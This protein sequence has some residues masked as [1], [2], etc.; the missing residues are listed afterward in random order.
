MEMYEL[1][2]RYFVISVIGSVLIGILCGF[3]S[4]W[5]KVYSARVKQVVWLVLALYFIVPLNL[6]LVEPLAE[7]QILGEKE[8]VLYDTFSGQETVL[9]STK[10]SE[11]SETQEEAKPMVQGEKVTENKENISVWQG[12]A[13]VWVAGCCMS[14][15][16][17]VLRYLLYRKYVLRWSENVKYEELGVLFN[18][19]AEEY[20]ISGRIP[21]RVSEKVSSPLLLGFLNPCIL[22]PHN[23]YEKTDLETIIRHELLHY[24]RKDVWCKVI[25]VIV[26]AIHWFNPMVYMMNKYANADM[27][28]ACDDC[29]LKGKS[30]EQ[31]KEYSEI[32]LATVKAQKINFGSSCFYGGKEMLKERF[33]NIL[34]MKKKRSG[35][36]F[37]AMLLLLL[38]CVNSLVACNFI[39]EMSNGKIA[40]DEEAVIAFSKQFVNEFQGA[41]AG[42]DDIELSEYIRNDNLLNFAER[43]IVLTQKQITAG[44]TSVLYGTEN[45][46]YR[47]ECSKINETIWYVDLYFV[48]QGC[49]QRCQ[50]LVDTAENME[51][52]DFYFGSMDGIDTICTGHI[53]ER[54]VNEPE[55]W[56]KEEWVLGVFEKMLD[57][58]GILDAK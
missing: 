24:K 33:E 31:R 10:G 21:V 23:D 11:E 8:I 47:K 25:L 58:E 15:G 2:C 52:L 20:K 32:I 16:Y 29:A 50:M 4:C 3:A 7:I 46:F 28:R 37:F 36:V 1:F 35:S 17:E 44:G 30:F 9:L 13:I 53:S 27:E 42:E 51:I 40:Y 49:G 45:A 34:N 19:I 48:Y 12:I 5:N 26:K 14:F 18:E 57:Y 54:T 56:E 38:V 6:P 43:M 55:L 39:P 22:L 41:I